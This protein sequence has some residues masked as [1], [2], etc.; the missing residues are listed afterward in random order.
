M[1]FTSLVVHEDMETLGKKERHFL[2]RNADKQYPVL[3]DF[4]ERSVQDIPRLAGVP[5]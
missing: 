5:A 3:A 4:R 2:T 1:L